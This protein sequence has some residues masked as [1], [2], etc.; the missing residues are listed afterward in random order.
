MSNQFIFDYSILIWFD[1]ITL[2]SY[3][4]FKIIKLPSNPELFHYCHVFSGQSSDL[5]C[6][7]GQK[8]I[9]FHFSFS[10]Y[11]QFRSQTA[12]WFST[13]F[14]LKNIL[15]LAGYNPILSFTNNETIL[16]P[17]NPSSSGWFFH[18]FYIL[19]TIY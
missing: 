2:W 16:F 15:L 8:C 10:L 7:Q 18:S 4:I 12:E 17:T 14:Y 3:L 19:Y 9:F 5:F 11:A 6:S 13:S 1:L